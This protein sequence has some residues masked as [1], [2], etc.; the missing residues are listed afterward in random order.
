MSDS[1]AP[2]VPAGSSEVAET[3]A[4][5]LQTSTVMPPDS[6]P[7]T[8]PGEST[9]HNSTDVPPTRNVRKTRKRPDP[10]PPVE[11]HK[12][13]EEKPKVDGE[14]AK[15]SIES[16]VV[17]GGWGYWGSWGK[18]IMST[19]SATVATVGQGITQAIEKAETSLGIP[20][21]TELSAQIG[22]EDKQEGEPSNETDKGEGDG[23]LAMGSAIGMFSSLSSVVQSTGKTVLTGGLDALEFI[24]K[25]TMDVIAEGDP[26]YKKTKG[27]MNRTNTL[28]QVLREA[29]ERE[30]QETAKE[31]SSD[32]ENKAHYGMLFDEFQG[33]SHLEALEIL[34][35]ESE[36]KV[37]SVL[38]TLSGEELDQLKEDLELI[39]EPFSLVEFDEE[40]VNE[41][42]DEDGSEFLRELT[43][44]LDGLHISTKADK[45]GKDVHSL[46]IRNLA[47]LTARSIEQFHK[48]AEMILFYTSQEVTT[49]EQAKI[50]S[51]ITIVLCK[52][53]S[54]LSKKFTSCLTTIGS[55]KKGDVLNP[56]ITG[57]FLEASNSASYIQDA[58]QLLMP[59]L[60]VSHIQRSADST[61]Q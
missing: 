32:T 21:P 33:L 47:E 50:L 17:Q 24:G 3:E 38:T 20:S 18:S 57:V 12:T 48:V 56:L 37:K 44:A 8:L 26:G 43:G 30:E 5:P 19:A 7:Q 34:S 36:S 41:K 58:F 45:L 4:P 1:K 52:E 16:T 60:E 35:R 13:Q 40:E 54:L 31:M 15:T 10:K 28:S 11:V 51:Q 22:E 9:T 59:V 42:K 53:I 46:A 61:Q 14:P 39:K 25:K 23:A 6:A 2:G 55:N 49:L 29:K 27:L